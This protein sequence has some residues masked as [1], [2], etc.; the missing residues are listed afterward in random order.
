M[1][2]LTPKWPKSAEIDT[3]FMT[4]T[5]EKPYPHIP[6]DNICSQSKFSS[7]AITLTTKDNW[8]FIMSKFGLSKLDMREKN[9]TF[10][11]YAS[12]LWPKRLK[13]LSFGA[14]HTYT[15]HTR[16]YPPPALC[17]GSPKTCSTNIFKVRA[18]DVKQ[19]KVFEFNLIDTRWSVVSSQELAISSYEKTTYIF[20]YLFLLILLRYDA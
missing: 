4:K 13:T 16:E 19:R 15:A 5:A 3:L 12:W 10:T 9:P 14:A 18:A 1:P 6:M 8:D 20:Q 17:G 11:Q 7:Q 2:Y